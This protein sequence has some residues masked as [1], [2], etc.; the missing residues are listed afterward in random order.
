MRFVIKHEIKGRIH[1]HVLQ[2]RMSYEQADTLEYYLNQQGCVTSVR[3]RE[4]IQDAVICYTGDR[5]AMI[6]VLRRFQYDAVRVPDT[7]L[8]NSG[9]ELNE[10]YFEQLVDKIVL[11]YGCKLLIPQPIRMVITWTKA[12]KYIWLGLKCLFAGKIEVAVLDATAILVSLLRN[13]CNTAG[14]VMFLLG[15]GE[16]LEE[17]THKKSVDALARSMALNVGNVWLKRDGQEILVPVS[18]VQSGDQVVVHMGNVIPFDGMVVDGDAMVN[19]ASLT[20]ESMPVHKTVEGYVYAGTVIEE[21]EITLLVKE[22]TGSSKYESIVTMIEESEKPAIRDEKAVEIVKRLDYDFSLAKKDAAMGSGV[23]A[24]T[25]VLDKLV[26][27][28]LNEHSNAVVVNIACG[29]DTRCYRNEGHYKHW[30]NLDL[31][32]TM[33][34]RQRFL[35]EDGVISQIA[36]SAM[37][38]AW[39]TQIEQTDEPV[40]IIIEGLTMYLSEK[41]VKTIFRIISER[42]PQ[43]TV[44]VEIMSPKMAKHFKEKSIEGSKAKFTWGIASGK[45]MEALLPGYNCL[46]EHS[47]TEGM[48]E[49]ISVYK[50][51][52]KIP[53]VRNI[54]NKILVMKLEKKF[55]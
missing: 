22:T 1:I 12:L 48:A 23:I 2:N 10:T 14:S 35:K 21:G 4:R 53:V 47:L 40:L 37:D 13:D 25:I 3:V 51:L 33:E 24:R 41:D 36:A 52:N 27:N 30:Y 9:R 42:F 31:P 55:Y 49:F 18:E 34:V 26:G 15:I 38:A 19:Q 16:I 50:L 17:W 5:N 8:Q 54:S 28:Y 46:E 45:E 6:D 20:G 7:C 32:E 11:H 44:L 43:A 29:M 39:A